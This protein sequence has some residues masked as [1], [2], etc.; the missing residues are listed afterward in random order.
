MSLPL[1]P[2]KKESY[3]SRVDC[4]VMS[5]NQDQLLLSTNFCKKYLL[6]V[7]DTILSFNLSC[8][9]VAGATNQKIHGYSEYNGL[10]SLATN[11]GVSICHWDDIS[12][13]TA[14]I[15]SETTFYSTTWISDKIVAG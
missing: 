5:P 7:K 2:V 13:S 1:Q 15:D 11:A 9:Q 3:F 4:A 8:T 12:I 6:S 10:Y 14:A